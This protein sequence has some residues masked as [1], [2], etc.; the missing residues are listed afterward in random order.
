MNFLNTVGAAQLERFYDTL[1]VVEQDPKTLIVKIVS[2]AR[3]TFLGMD[4]NERDQNHALMRYIAKEI[5]RINQHVPKRRRRVNQAAL[6]KL[7]RLAPARPSLPTLHK[8]VLIYEIYARLEVRS[9]RALSST[10]R[11]LHKRI[12]QHRMIDVRYHPSFKH[13]MTELGRQ[14]GKFKVGDT[15]AYLNL[16]GN[17]TVNDAWIQELVKWAPNLRLLNLKS[18]RITDA[19][20]SC[21]AIDLVNLN[22]IN[23]ARCLNVGDKSV[24][25]FVKHCKIRKI[26]FTYHAGRIGR[27]SLVTLA[28]MSQLTSISI[29]MHG[30]VTSAFINALTKVKKLEE[31]SL[32]SA[33]NIPV[34]L[35]DRIKNH[36]H[37]RIISIEGKDSTIYQGYI[38]Y[39]YIQYVNLT[40]L[41]VIG[42]SEFHSFWFEKAFK[43]LKQLEVLILEST[44]LTDSAF[45]NL[46][47]LTKLNHLSLADNLLTSLTL[48]KLNTLP[49]LKFLKLSNSTINGTRLPPLEKL[50]LLEVLDLSRF[51]YLSDNDL[52]VLNHFRYLR[53][54][55]L[56]GLYDITG[57]VFKNISPLTELETLDLSNSRIDPDFLVHL[58]DFKN[59]RFLNLAGIYGIKR[60]QLEFL[61]KLPSA[62][63]N[64]N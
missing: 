41:E 30:F 20:I 21:I 48:S 47:E 55:Q 6:K 56:A 39:T 29:E 44:W 25:A 27:K 64:L 33:H 38:W 37:L 16:D 35:F 2:E 61:H 62:T 7:E 1:K 52:M 36:R 58:G 50:K 13:S 54:L 23:I 28:R 12:I 4:P 49:S 17:D 19:A 31:L 5:T 15:L 57:V 11:K 45:I 18:T 46:S 43:A 53:V 22:E 3:T 59:L 8:Q 42:C 40:K 60:K 9:K 34:I 51:D 14:I 26:K 24:S 10:S 32:K 63:V